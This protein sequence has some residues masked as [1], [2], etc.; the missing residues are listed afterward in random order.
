MSSSNI[1]HIK[2]IA[3]F[4][5]FA[6]GK[7]VFRF[8]QIEQELGIGKEETIHALDVMKHEFLIIYETMPFYPSDFQLDNP[9]DRQD[10]LFDKFKGKTLEEHE[11]SD[12]IMW[13]V[14]DKN[15]LKKFIES[16]D[17]IR[18]VAKKVGIF[19]SRPEFIEN[20]SKIIFQKKECPIPA[21]FE[22]AVCKIVFSR[23][24]G[25]WAIEGD[26]FDIADRKKEKTRSVKDAVIRVNKKVKK[27]LNIDNLIEYNNSRA[28][29][30]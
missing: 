18:E 10:D 20:E 7:S 21:G 17:I 8:R 24:L 12:G 14:K 15:K 25:E 28:R 3:K 11:N 4:I 9:K 30:R 29:I 19:S 2:T 13:F 26:I 23:P 22:F 1:D 5:L 27:Y 16:D 6:E